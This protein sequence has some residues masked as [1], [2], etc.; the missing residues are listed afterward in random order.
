MGER[1]VE[2]GCVAGDRPQLERPRTGA[3]DPSVDFERYREAAC[4]RFIAMAR[5]MGH[6]AYHDLDELAKDFYDDFWTEWLERPRRELSG[7][8]VPYIAGAMMNKLRDLSRRGRSVRA[9]DI[10]RSENEAILATIAAE[11]LEPGEQVV[12]QEAMW[13]VSEIVHTLPEREQVAFAAVFG[14]DSRKK[15]A[16]PGGYKLAAAALGVSETRAKKLSLAANKRIRA[17]VQKIE[18]GSW[19][20]RW[21][22]SIETVAAGGQADPAFLT[23]VEHCAQCRLGIV[24]LRRHAAILPAPV[25]AVG[26]EHIGWVHRVFGQARAAFRGLRDDVAGLF[27]RHA[28]TANDASGLVGASGGAAGAGITAIKVGAICV[29]VGLTGSA[30]L[31]AVGVPSPIITAISGGHAHARKHHSAH[32]AGPKLAA[33]HIATISLANATVPSHPVLF[34]TVG[35]SHPA[36]HPAASGRSHSQPSSSEA[37][38]EF[39]PGGGS[40]GQLPAGGSGGSVSADDASVHTV[41]SGSSTST[42]STSTTRH[43]APSGSGSGSSGGGTATTS[44]SSNAFNAP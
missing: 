10:V 1:L 2:P 40:G 41:R 8:A 42:T 44:S 28:A 7:P 38:T 14:R 25:L 21:A 31:Q 36:T 33:A 24:H 26:S 35:H 23:H 13:L 19:C 16:P 43:T 27:G 32:A 15:G 3:L 4:K 9:P 11:E 18:A 20:D 6:H 39:H 12:L 30:C 34:H 22:T 17:A 29:G 37:Q 5:T